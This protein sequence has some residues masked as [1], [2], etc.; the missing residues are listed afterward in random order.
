MLR[1]MVLCAGLG[2]RLK[3]L[4]DELPKPLVPVGDR[5]LLAHI[6]ATLRGAGIDGFVV[7]THHLGHEF[8]K[9]IEEISPNIHVIYEPVIR[10]TAGGIAGARALFSDAGALVWNGDVFTK[11]PIGQLLQAASVGGLTLSVATVRSPGEGTVGLDESDRVVRLRGER[12]GVEVRGADYI[13]VAALGQDVL[14]A[15]P[16][17][18]CL[19]G[20]VALPHL[21]AGGAI[22]TVRSSALFCD[23]GDVKGYFRANLAWLEGFGGAS[24]LG[25]GAGIETE[26]EPERSIVGAGARVEGK[27]DLVRCVVWPG[28]RAKAPLA[29]AIVTRRTIVKVS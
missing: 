15:L 20:D 7:N 26:V 28:A 5:P 10:G 9:S 2:T 19:I 25:E 22:A 18:G 24:W 4:T 29:D 12:F 3:P 8:D 11:P 27:G 21:R 13:G 14:K 23:I 1:A 17:Q 16:E 6:A